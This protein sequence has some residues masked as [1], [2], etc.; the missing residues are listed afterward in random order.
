VDYLANARRLADDVLFPAAL[1]TDAADTVPA[2]L[3]DSLADAGLY[4]FVLDADFR[5]AC[6]VIE[7]LASGCLT[8]TFVWV[9]HLGAVRAAALSEYEQVRDEWREPL[10]SGRIRGGLALGGALPGPPALRARETDEGWLFDGVSPFLS[11]WGRIDVI[12]AAARTDDGRLVWAFVDARASETLTV[13]RLSLAALNATATMRADFHEHPVAQ[14][15]MV[16]IATYGDGQPAPELLRIHSSLALGVIARCCLLLGPTPLDDE[17]ATVRD[18]LDRLDPETIAAARAAAGELALRA[19]AALMTATGSRSLLL[20]EHAQRL[21]REALF[22]LVYALRPA[23]K[24][25]L[26]TGLR[27]K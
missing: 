26:L 2:E 22:V 7:A 4:G 23:S 14:E 18:E 6:S 15:R 13:Q 19:A 16:E 5:T 8:T 11:G 24:D 12:H 25:A 1:T 21:A 10:A 17:L 9:Q 3:L 27:A 20:S